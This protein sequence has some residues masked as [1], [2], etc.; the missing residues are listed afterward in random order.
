MGKYT[1]AIGA[2]VTTA[3]GIWQLATLANSAG[4][5]VVTGAEL[6]NLAVVSVGA[7]I[8]VW[9]LPNDKGSGTV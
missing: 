7:G 2:F 5:P 3:L 8:L 9:A 6:V 1:K 4:G